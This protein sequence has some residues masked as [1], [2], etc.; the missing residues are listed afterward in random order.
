MERRTKKVDI[1]YKL[2][3]SERGVPDIPIKDIVQFGIPVE[4]RSRFFKSK[5]KNRKCFN[6][7]YHVYV[8]SSDLKKR[9]TVVPWSYRKWKKL[10]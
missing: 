3:A 10:E 5:Y 1:H 6:F 4:R 7:D 9:I 8:L 2:R